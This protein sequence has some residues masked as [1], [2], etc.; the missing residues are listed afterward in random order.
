MQH[1]KVKMLSCTHNGSVFHLRD[2]QSV[3]Q[4]GER[5]EVASR[6]GDQMA[7]KRICMVLIARLASSISRDSII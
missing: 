7:P 4:W 5:S 3:A 2:V 1:V 6:F